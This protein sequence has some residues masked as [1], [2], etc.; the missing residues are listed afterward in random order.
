MAGSGPA[1]TRE[2]GERSC[3]PSH[4]R[5]ALGVHGRVVGAGTDLF[6]GSGSGW[7]PSRIWNGNF[8]FPRFSRDSDTMPGANLHLGDC[9]G[10]EGQEGKEGREEGSKV[11]AESREAKGEEELAPAASWGLAQISCHSLSSSPGLSR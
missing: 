2:G 1:M 5:C 3:P 11:E 10:E 9:D 7:E 8:V 6:G 4:A